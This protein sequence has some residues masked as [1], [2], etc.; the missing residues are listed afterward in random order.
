MVEDK[1]ITT[2]MYQFEGHRERAKHSFEDVNILIPTGR[3][4]PT[5]LLSI[6]KATL[7]RKPKSTTYVH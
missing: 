1:L 4:Q 7:S 6:L 2:Q 5:N 3:V